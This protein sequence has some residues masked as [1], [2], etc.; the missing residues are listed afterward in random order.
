MARGT[1]LGWFSLAGFVFTCLAQWVAVAE[2]SQPKNFDPDLE[3]LYTCY[4]S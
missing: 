4:F 3:V 1:G 2:S